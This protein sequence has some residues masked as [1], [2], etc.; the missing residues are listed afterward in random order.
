M[1]IGS[2]GDVT[3]VVKPDKLLSFNGLTLDSDSG[4]EEHQRIKKKSHLEFTG[5]ELK[6][7]SQTVYV[8]MQYGYKPMSVYSKLEKMQANGTAHYFTLGGVKLG[9]CLW[10]ITSMHTS[11]SSY[12]RD[13]TPT[14]ATF[15]LK[16][17]EY[18]HK[19]KKKKE[20][21]QKTKKKNP[22]TK[23]ASST[24]VSHSPKNVHYTAYIIKAGD[25]LWA[26]AKRY[27]GRGSEYSKIYSANRKKDKGFHVLTNPNV[28]SPGWKIKIPK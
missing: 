28:L 22:T 10:V 19:A 9:G 25:T 1:K 2:F 17:K 21:G 23:R 7:M 18:P 26:L 13:G 11:F 24:P 20:K 4:W 12:W 3:F 14:K 15:E 27:Y 5:P 8:D 16:F 6:V